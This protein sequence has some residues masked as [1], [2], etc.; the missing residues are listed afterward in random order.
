MENRSIKDSLSEWITGMKM[1]DC[2]IYVS[3]KH[4]IEL[5]KKDLLIDQFL[6]IFEQFTAIKVTEGKYWIITEN[7]VYGIK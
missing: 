5:S 1:I 7:L 4:S 2:S 6:E 3:I